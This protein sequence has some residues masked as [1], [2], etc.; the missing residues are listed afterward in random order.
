[1]TYIVLDVGC[2]SSKVPGAVGIDHFKN[3]SVDIVH[4]LNNIPWPFDAESVDKIIFSHS[5]SHLHDLPAV[6]SECFR[7][8]K[9]G[10][11]IEIIAPHYSSDNFNTDPTHKI[12]MGLRSMNY[13]ARNVEFKYRYISDNELF[14]IIQ[15]DISFREAAVTWRESVKFNPAYWLGIEYLA[16]KFPRV[17]EKYFCWIIPAS[18][19]HFVLL[20]ER[21]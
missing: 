14:S 13:F 10:G 21:N 12:H 1:M 19:L 8:L 6:M 9:W 4:D 7:I 17:Y 15:K 2:G 3:P 11:L 16:N 18:E 20:K 5:I